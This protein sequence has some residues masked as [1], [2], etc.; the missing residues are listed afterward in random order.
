MKNTNG[1]IVFLTAALCLVLLGCQS[2]QKDIQIPEAGEAAYTGLDALEETVVR[3]DG[4][5][6]SREEL[7]QARQQVTALQ[8]T[9]ADTAFDAL[10]AAWSG[11][12]YLMEGKTSDAQ[13]EYRKSQSL[14]PLNIP[15][16]VLSFRLE[17][18][19][20]RRLAMIDG[21]LA[22]ET[23]LGSAGTGSS[24]GTSVSRGVLLVERGRVLLDM[25]RFS[26]SVAAFDTAFVLLKGKPYYE[27]AY[28]IFR[29]KAWELKDLQEGTGSRTVEIAGQGEI[30]WKDLLDITKNETDLLK[31]ITAGRDWPTESLFTQLLDRAFIPFT[32]DPELTEWPIAKP[33][34]SEIVYRSGAAWFLWHVYAENRANRGLLTRYSARFA[35][36]P[37]AKSPVADLNIRSPFLDSILGCVESEFMSLPDGK[38]FMPNVKVKGS[39]FLG[40]VRKM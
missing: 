30:T 33:S 34:S 7:V 28:G 20:S 9:V 21:S 29:G 31:F 25:N 26:E 36:N 39:E 40:M 4:A 18:D 15:A 24:P 8:G 11:R 32:Q 2:V 16:Q 10:L 19:L 38:N 35:N 13:R 14:S 22:A 5:G 27:E 23:S 6:A 37:N 3:L 1:V 12:I 17:Q